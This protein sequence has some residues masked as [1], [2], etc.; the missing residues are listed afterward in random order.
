MVH[1][2]FHQ[3]GAV[4]VTLSF[5]QFETDPVDAEDLPEQ[6]VERPEMFQQVR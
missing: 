3:Q 4:L 1:Y 2:P 5:L 6:L